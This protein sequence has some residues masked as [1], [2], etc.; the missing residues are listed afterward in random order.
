M[1]K[2]DGHLVLIL[3]ILDVF[4]R[5]V[6]PRV[7][8]LD[9]CWEVPIFFFAKRSLF[10]KI[11]YYGWMRILLCNMCLYATGAIISNSFPFFPS[12]YLGDYICWRTKFYVGGATA[13]RRAIVQQVKLPLHVSTNCSACTPLII[14]LL[15]NLL[16]WVCAPMYFA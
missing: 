8:I 13:I 11:L 16:G 15:Y 3:I 5:Y 12:M 6:M 10:K 14:Y 9:W 7:W 2:S 4:A 1:I